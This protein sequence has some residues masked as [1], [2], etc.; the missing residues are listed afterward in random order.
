MEIE[1]VGPDLEADKL[2]WYQN[3]SV[4]KQAPHPIKLQQLYTQQMHLNTSNRRDTFLN[5][6]SWGDNFP[7]A[8]DSD[9]YAGS[10]AD[11]RF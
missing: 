6:G 11:W 10:L 2:D 7:A 1:D 4:T 3:Y 9:E 5:A 8:G